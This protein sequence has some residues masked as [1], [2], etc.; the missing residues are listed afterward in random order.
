[1]EIFIEQTKN[2]LDR[3]CQRLEH[4]FALTPDDRINWSPSPTARTPM[5]LILHAAY[6]LEGIQGMVSGEKFPYA[7]LAEADAAWREME[8]QPTT[9]AQTLAMLHE[10]SANYKKWLDS[11]TLEKLASTA[12]LPF[13][14]MPYTQAIIFGK[15]HT[16]FHSAQLEYVQTCYGDHDWYS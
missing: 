15:M 16:A 3:A 6:A 13:G 12:V 4:L 11:F 10:K 5:E 9:R 7:S 2:E 1:M 14:E 8:K